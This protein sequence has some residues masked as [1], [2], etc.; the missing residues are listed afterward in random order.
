[1]SYDITP[2]KNY[3]LF[4]KKQMNLYVSIHPL[5]LEGVI[6]TSEL[7]TFNIHEPP[8]CL[9]VKSS[10]DAQKR[11]IEKQTAVLEKSKNGRFVGVCHAGVKEYVYPIFSNEKTVGFIC[12]SGYSS[13]NAESYVR[14]LHEKYNFPLDSLTAAY[15]SLRKDLPDEKTVDTLLA[16]LCQMLEL[17]YRKVDEPTKNNPFIARVLAY[18]RQYYTLPITSETLCA[19]FYCSRSHLSHVFNKETGK[20]LKE[21]LTGLRLNAA[22]ALLK[23]SEM[24]ITEIALSVGFSDSNYFSNVFKKQTGLSPSKYKKTHRLSE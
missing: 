5:K 3:L 19:E 9:Y 12:V 20:T 10:T 13:E 6:S 14:A 23:N 22:K 21:Y 11:C 1:M 24:N 15:R 17:A 7:A 2:I 18:V 8:Y 16:P 4:L